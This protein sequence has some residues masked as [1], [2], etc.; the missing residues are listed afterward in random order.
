MKKFLSILIVA[1]VAIS[2]MQAQDN[3]NYLAKAF[4]LLSK[5]NL[6]S[7]EKHYIVHKKLTGQMDADFEAMLQEEKG[8]STNASWKDQCY[9]VQYDSKYMLAVQKAS[10]TDVTRLGQRDAVRAASCS[11]LGGFMDWKLPTEMEM[12]VLIENLPWGILKPSKYW[13]RTKKSY[14]NVVYFNSFNERYSTNSLISTYDYVIVR[15]Y[16]K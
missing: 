7:A 6:E 16:R 2:V 11:R 1:F 15:K 5:G 12:S 13:T 3:T 4:E 8:K 14:G 9:I 10:I